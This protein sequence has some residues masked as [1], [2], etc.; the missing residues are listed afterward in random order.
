M[1]AKVTDALVAV[2]GENLRGVTW[3]R[4]N[5]FE[6]GQWASA[7]RRCMPPTCERWQPGRP[8][9]AI[10]PALFRIRG[11]GSGGGV[12]AFPVLAVAM[13]RQRNRG[14]Q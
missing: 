11:G 10:L 2:E 8:P 4:I 14:Q 7:A 9:D 1:I 12:F 5:E 3:V 13:N 6:G